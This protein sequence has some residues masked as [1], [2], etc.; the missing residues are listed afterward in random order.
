MTVW[1]AHETG[2]L[3]NLRRSRNL[4][5]L[6]GVGCPT[7]HAAGLRCLKRGAAQHVDPSITNVEVSLS[8]GGDRSRKALLKQHQNRWLCCGR[9]SCRLRA[10]R[11]SH[12]VV[13]TLR[14]QEC[15]EHALQGHLLRHDLGHLMLSVGRTPRHFQCPFHGK[16]DA[17][18]FLPPSC[19]SRVKTSP[20]APARRLPKRGPETR[21][22]DHCSL[23]LPHHCSSAWA[24]A[25]C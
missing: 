2:H 21:G 15:D 25:H 4:S 23:R 10:W 16:Q 8:A 19:S 14:A 24:S 13:L 9:L 17:S 20:S 22:R 5:A 1:T 6:L 7:C 11:R 18:L 12:L 3:Q